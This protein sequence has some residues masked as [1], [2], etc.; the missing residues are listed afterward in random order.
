MREVA[1][2]GDNEV[3]TLLVVGAIKSGA[4]SRFSGIAIGAISSGGG[5]GGGGA[6][7]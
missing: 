1:G 4:P 5:G 3:G 2:G 6:G 7:G